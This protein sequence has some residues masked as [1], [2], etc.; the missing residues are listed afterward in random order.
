V[1]V[2]VPIVGKID[3]GARNV[4][5]AAVREK[6]EIRSDSSLLD[7]LSSVDG[8]DRLETDAKTQGQRY[9]AVMAVAQAR[10]I[11]QRNTLSDTGH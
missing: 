2:W 7:K 9:G 11:G 8:M 10:W 5:K 6:K 3:W 1:R 4:K